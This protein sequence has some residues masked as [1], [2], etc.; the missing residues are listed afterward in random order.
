MKLS[1]TWVWSN[2]ISLRFGSPWVLFPLDQL[3]NVRTVLM[4]ENC[5]CSNN[6]FWKIVKTLQ[7]CITLPVFLSS[8][9]E[10]LWVLEIPMSWQSQS[11]AVERL[12][13]P[14]SQANEAP[15]VWVADVPTHWGHF[16]GAPLTLAVSFGHFL[17]F[18][19]R[20]WL[21]F[22]FSKLA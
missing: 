8:N 10:S 16:T 9:Y 19:Q 5:H 1:V 3:E 2:S 14:Q 18:W 7:C 17:F 6:R 22:F 13:L 20:C 15:F 4:L 21:M 11:S 12:L